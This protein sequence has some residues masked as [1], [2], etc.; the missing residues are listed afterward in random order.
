MEDIAL[1]TIKEILIARGRNN[2]DF[3]PVGGSPDETKMYTFDSILIIF[4]TKTRVTEKELN[5][6]LKF[7]AENNH[8]SGILVATPSRPSEM[9]L[10]ILRNH[11]NDPENPL[12]Q[13]FELRHLQ[14]DISKH[15]KVPRHRIITNDEKNEVLKEFNI[16]DS[17][18]LPKIDSQDPMAKWI[19][20]RPSDVIEVVGLCESSGLNRRYRLCVAD[21]ANA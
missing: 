14:F 12:V 19:G 11:I 21:V 18:Y 2:T 1:A 17:S 4:S 15:R 8:T 5:N 6:F 13:I 9:V 7:A 16:S 20:A 3:E 10:N